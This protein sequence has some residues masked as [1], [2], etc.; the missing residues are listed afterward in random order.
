M[1]NRCESDTK[2]QI[3]RGPQQPEKHP[4]V[5]MAANQEIE[6]TYHYTD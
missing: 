3:C 5:D 2:E 4:G 6:I 1:T